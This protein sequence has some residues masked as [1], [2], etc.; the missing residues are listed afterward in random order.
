MKKTTDSLLSRTG[1]VALRRRA[2]WILKKI[3]TKNPKSILDVGCGDGFYLHLL[4]ALFPK[5]KIVGMDNDENA[6]KSAS[7][8]LKGKNVKLK[9]GNIYNLSFVSNS[10]DTV[11]AS[12]ILE[13]LEDDS[14][15]L[16]EIHRV[17]R[18]G[19]LLLIS[20]PHANYPILWDPINWFIEKIFNTHI[21]KGFFSGI[22]NQHERLYFKDQLTRLV[23]KAGFK[24]VK[25]GTLTHICLP[26]N[27]YLL[28]IFARILAK[29]SNSLAKNTLSKFSGGRKEGINPFW[30]LF[31]FDKLN[32]IFR[33]KRT[34]VSVVVSAVKQ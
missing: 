7:V 23:K 30:L 24:N 34:G 21:K 16:K 28:N 19:G 5:A 11:L 9:H 22:W 29:R 12:E 20:V 15:G 3:K 17:L 10:F 1:D 26:F 2:S 14:K 18:P 4:A 27:H 33:S 8:N 32:D 6:L 13:H 31:Q 25:S